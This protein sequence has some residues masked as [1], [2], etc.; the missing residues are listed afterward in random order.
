MR[1]LMFNKNSFRILASF[2]TSA[3]L[4]AGGIGC[5]QLPGTSKQQGAVIG[6]VGG[7]VA[8]AAVG[9]ERHRLLGAILGGA[10]GAGGGYVIGAN[11]DRIMGRDSQGAQEAVRNAQTSPATPQQ[12]RNAPT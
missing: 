9:G 12:A 2:A 3:V 6:G 5:E 10:V 7:A 11:S 8:G 1:R 4:L